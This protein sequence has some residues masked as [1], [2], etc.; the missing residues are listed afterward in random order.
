MFSGGIE[1]KP[2]VSN[3]LKTTN[4]PQQKNAVAI[5]F[6]ATCT[7]LYS[8]N[9]SIN[10]IHTNNTSQEEKQINSNESWH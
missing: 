7:Q 2:I 10:I 1:N 4:Q 5:S 9:A 6:Y 8:G 3:E